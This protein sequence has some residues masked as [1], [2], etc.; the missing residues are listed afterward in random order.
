MER[1]IGRKRRWARNQPGDTHVGPIALIGEGGR[2]RFVCGINSTYFAVLRQVGQSWDTTLASLASKMGATGTTSHVLVLVVVT[3]SVK[4]N[5]FSGG[6]CGCD[7]IKLWD[8][9]EDHF[10][11]SK[12][13]MCLRPRKWDCCSDLFCQH[14]RGFNK[15]Q[16]F[17]K[18]NRM[19]GFRGTRLLIEGLQRCLHVAHLCQSTMLFGIVWVL[20]SLPTRPFGY[21]Q[22]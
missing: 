19:A 13:L 8:A 15:P 1:L 10:L 6:P 17:G 14:W 7:R 2:D 3:G 12:K 5:L 20:L 21:D 16:C 4:P 22:V 9:M 18:S 11:E